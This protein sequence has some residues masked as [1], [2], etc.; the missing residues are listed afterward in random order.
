[1]ASS[2]KKKTT[3]AKLNRERKLR[4]R[5]VDKQAKKDA[6]RHASGQQPGQSGDMPT[7]GDDHSIPWEAGQPA[8]DPVVQ[9]LDDV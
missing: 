9:S 6:R 3:M 2:S 4:E 5:R 1:M 8:P 7:V